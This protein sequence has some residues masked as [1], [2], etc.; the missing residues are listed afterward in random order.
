MI[1]PIEA[2]TLRSTGSSDA[3]GLRTWQLSRLA[4]TVAY[5][6]THS[7]FYRERLG[8]FDGRL[9]SLPF[10]EPAD[11]ARD[12][13]AFLCVPQREIARVTTLTTSG[14]TGET[15]RIFFTRADLERTVDFF[16]LGM[17]MLVREEQDTLILLGADTECSIA[18]LLQTAIGRLGVHG[19]IGSL[20]WG[21][22]ETLAAA[23]TAD[24]I[25]GLPAELLYL[26]RLDG[27]LRP[28]TVLLSADF[29]PECVIATLRER[30]GCRV[31]THFGMTET[32]YG[33][34][35]Q[36]E[37]G[38]GHHVRHP[39]LMLEI[40]D[41]VT[42]EPLPPGERGELVLTLL[43]SEAMPLLRYRTGDIASLLPGPCPCGGIL[44]RLGRVEGRWKNDLPLNQGQAL[45][46]HQLDELLFAVPA[47]R[48]F[49]AGLRREGDRNTLFLTIEADGVL[50]EDALAAQ[51]PTAL[52][53]QVRYADASPFSRKG[54]RR[55]HADGGACWEPCLTHRRLEVAP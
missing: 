32:G 53:L 27:S 40:L 46:I 16:A 23:R 33:C 18:R 52:D 44:P 41:P 54:K 3:A 25:V 34:A 50:E 29:V 42:G 43:A 51:L 26:C 45:S 49:E 11:L 12:P 37:A 21:A 17:G 14:S 30:W 13:L 31:F 39:E 38:E 24:C 48:G 7:R 55:I 19:R 28:A 20:A 4:E 10:T 2:W 9:E 6:Q 8:G 1:C 22:G 47:L 5:A 35:V 15:K 36:C